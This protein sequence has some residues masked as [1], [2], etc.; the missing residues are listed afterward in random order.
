MSELVARLATGRHPVEITHR[1]SSTLEAF[2]EAVD[3]GYVHVKFT[4]TRGGTELGVRLASEE[5]EFDKANFAKGSGSVKIVG[6][7]TLDYVPVQCMAEI[8]LGT[9]TGTGWLVP[10][11]AASAASDAAAVDKGR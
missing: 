9:L 3:R 4:K 5:C 11:Q 1:P 7:L 2:K 6:T 8:D 10:R